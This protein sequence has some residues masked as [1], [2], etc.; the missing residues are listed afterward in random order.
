[1]N[2]DNKTDENNN[3]STIDAGA[4]P[5]NPKI[6]LNISNNSTNVSSS[7]NNAQPGE[8]S[9]KMK[10]MAQSLKTF[11][12]KAVSNESKDETTDSN[13][14]QDCRKKAL[15]YL[16]E[17]VE[18]ETNYK[19][20]IILISIGSAMSCLSLLFLPMVI[21]SPRKFVSFFSLGSL[22]ILTSFLFFYGTKAYF[23]K[24]CSKERYI[25]S[26]LFVGSVLLGIFCAILNQFFFLT[27]LCAAV[28]LLSLSVFSLSFIPGGSLGISAIKNMVTAPIRGAWA[29]IRGSS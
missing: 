5:E 9:K 1:M 24:L 10:N 13:N 11:F 20:F 29:S 17:K 26:G 22:L 23:A 18:V 8:F 12:T 6:D 27:L 14:D 21:I 3:Y 4:D 28:Q 2:S 19:V 16:Q 7:D 15:T 25:F